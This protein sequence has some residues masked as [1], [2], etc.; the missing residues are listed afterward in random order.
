M[1]VV[2]ADGREIALGGRVLDYPENL[3]P[4]RSFTGC[5]AR[6]ATPMLAYTIS[7]CLARLFAA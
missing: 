3:P 5:V 7:F 1:K 6:T 2:L 4:G